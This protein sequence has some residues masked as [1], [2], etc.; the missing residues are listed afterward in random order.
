MDMTQ[1]RSFLAI[2]ETGGFGRAAAQC[3]IT[4]PSLSQQIK[5]LESSLGVRLFDRLGRRIALTGAGEALVPR[6]RRILAEVRDVQEMLQGETINDRGRLRIGAIPT[7]APYLLPPAV[8]A[9]RRSHAGTTISLR[10]DLTDRLV[11]GLVNCELDLAVMSAPVDDE[12]IELEV[13]GREKLIVAMPRGFDLPHADRLR[14]V[15]LRDQP[16]VVLHEMHCL[17]RQIDGFCS[18]KGITRHIVCRSTQLATVLEMVAL[19]LGVSI[20]PQMCADADRSRLRTYLP[21][22][23][24]GP[25]REITLAWRIGRTREQTAQAFGAT[26]REIVESADTWASRAGRAQK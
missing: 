20:V 3:G 17:G 4:Q 16:A 2:V 14:L 1:L 19:G 6:A 22:M 13:I 24:G 12:R 21:I 23:R 15:D 10:E 8:R 7:M 25:E 5:R 9:F 26:L 11:E 18:A